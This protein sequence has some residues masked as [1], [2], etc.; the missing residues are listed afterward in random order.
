MKKH[1]KAPRYF[2]LHVLYRGA[3]HELK[4]EYDTSQM[5]ITNRKDNMGAIDKL[6]DWWIHCGFAV[7]ILLVRSDDKVLREW[8]LTEDCPAPDLKIEW[9]S[10]DEEA[11]QPSL[12][13]KNV[14]W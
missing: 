8:K 7:S 14:E 11:V 9:N 4:G 10:S 2:Y 5:A 3:R 12:I 13:D 6:I 1:E